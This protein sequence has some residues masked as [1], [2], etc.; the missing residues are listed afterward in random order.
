MTLLEDNWDSSRFAAECAEQCGVEFDR[1]RGIDLYTSMVRRAWPEFRE[2]NLTRDA[3]TC[4]RFW[5]D[6]TRRWLSELGITADV[7]P[8]MAHA[9]QR[10]FSA[11]G[12]VFRKY[13][14][15][16]S[17]LIELK[18]RGYK[19]AVLSNWDQSLH[20]VLAAQD[21]TQY[22]DVVIASLEEGV[23]KPE[24]LIFEILLDKLGVPA[25]D[26]LHVGDNPL[27][28]YHGAKSAGME[29]RILDHSLTES[30]GAYIHR[31]GA[32]L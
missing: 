25:A 11:G 22:F 12:D 26:V 20:R 18:K 5:N 14:D 1:E 3:A 7:A 10:L 28:D 15:T 6:L 23:E 24:P 9:R 16:E 2:L 32:L 21:L 8:I 17:T 13:P 4:D 27:D 19:L 29:A 30:E 31:L